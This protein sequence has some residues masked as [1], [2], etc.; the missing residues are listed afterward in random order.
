MLLYFIEDLL[1]HILNKQ[2]LGL[3]TIE[4]MPCRSTCGSISDAF[5]TK[6]CDRNIT[7]YNDEFADKW[8]SFVINYSAMKTYT[9][10]TYKIIGL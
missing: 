9:N 3:K 8:E 5:V 10:D 6:L 4:I 7:C 1:L 2:K